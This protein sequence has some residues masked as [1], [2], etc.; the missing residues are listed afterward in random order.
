M[1]RNQKEK[2]LELRPLRHMS[3]AGMTH[4]A[5]IMGMIAAVVRRHRDTQRVN[6]QRRQN[7]TSKVGALE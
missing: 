1:I 5:M 2:K 7:E 3:I 4:A 6:S